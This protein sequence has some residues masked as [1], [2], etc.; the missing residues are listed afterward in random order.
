MFAVIAAY[1]DS[2]KSD[3]AY[4]TTSEFSTAEVTQLYEGEDCYSKV[5]NFAVKSEPGDILIL[6]ESI[7][8]NCNRVNS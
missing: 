7:I 8:V 5:F 3:T 4:M 2:V 6:R 1:P